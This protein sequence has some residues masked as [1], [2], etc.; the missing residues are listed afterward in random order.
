MKQFDDDVRQ[1]LK[2]VDPPEGFA[3]RVMSRIGR[4]RA[5]AS[6]ASVRQ[7]PARGWRGV[8]AAAV[9]I[10]FAGAG[11]YGIRSRQKVEQLEGLKAREEVLL[12]LSIAS[13]KTNAA[14]QA[15]IKP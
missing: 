6:V 1:A 13:E 15:V 14:R 3:D 12:A 10:A 9:L 8:A 11:M 2:Q 7:F 5:H 4:E